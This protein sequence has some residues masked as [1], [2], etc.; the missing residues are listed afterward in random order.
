MKEI[1]EALREKLKVK[2]HL[3][4]QKIINLKNKVKVGILNLI[5]KI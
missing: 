2:L 4:E 3:L 5:G 1:L